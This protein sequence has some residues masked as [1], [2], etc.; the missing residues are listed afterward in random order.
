MFSFFKETIKSIEPKTRERFATLEPITFPITIGPLFSR[1][2]KKVVSISGAE[3]P[4][5]ITVEPMKNEE[6]PNF[7]AVKTEN[8]SNFSALTHISAMPKAIAKNA[9]I[10]IF[11]FVL[12]KTNTRWYNSAKTNQIIFISHEIYL[13]EVLSCC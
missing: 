3:V 4:N 10:I 13:F 1:D 7:C 5:A 2:T 11:I 9:M 12:S 8:F 6:N